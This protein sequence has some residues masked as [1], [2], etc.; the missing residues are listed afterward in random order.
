MSYINIYIF[1][2]SIFFI[3]KIILPQKGLEPSISASGGPRLTIRPLKHD[4]II[5]I[6]D[7]IH[8]YILYNVCYT[9]SLSIMGILVI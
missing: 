8:L 3:R 9:L 4:L 7:I 6:R 1:R 5:N 2:K